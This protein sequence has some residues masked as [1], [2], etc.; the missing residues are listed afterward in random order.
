MPTIQSVTGHR[1][2]AESTAAT[3]KPLY[4]APM[5]FW[6]L[7]NFTKKVPITEVIMQAPPMAR[8]YSII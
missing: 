6:L 7:P 5:M 4:I 8:G 2:T 1:A 3:M